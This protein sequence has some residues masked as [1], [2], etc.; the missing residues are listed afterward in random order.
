MLGTTMVQNIL[1]M[2]LKE[3][4]KSGISFEQA[5]QHPDV[6]PMQIHST[7]PTHADTQRVTFSTAAARYSALA[8]EQGRTPQTAS[9]APNVPLC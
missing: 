5:L 7:K 9:D 6:S 2:C 4:D 1:N 8:Q 3:S